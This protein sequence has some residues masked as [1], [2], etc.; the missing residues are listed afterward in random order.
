MFYTKEAMEEEDEFK[1]IDIVPGR[2]VCAGLFFI[3]TIISVYWFFRIGEGDF[4]VLN[5][6]T[7]PYGIGVKI[8]WTKAY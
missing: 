5:S 7:G 2:E 6:H 1:D 3:F 8:F 4:L